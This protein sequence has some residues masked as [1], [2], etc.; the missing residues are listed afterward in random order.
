MK[1]SASNSIPAWQIEREQT[2]HRI[3]QHIKARIARGQ[4]R[5]KAVKIFSRRRNGRPL[6]SDPARKCA[7]SG[8]T[9][10]RHYRTWLRAGETPSAFRLRF[11]PNARR[12][13]APVLVRFVNF[14]ADRDFPSLRAAWE[15][16]CKRGGNYGPGRVRGRRLNLGYHSLRWNLPRGCFR[17]LKRC[18][19]VLRQT[20]QEI[21]VLRERTIA[22]IRA[23]VPDRLPRRIDFQI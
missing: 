9:L 21:A 22:D 12:I 1:P 8:G 7:I 5:F 14:I 3:C 18:R 2:L 17:E 23:R 16:F 6:K 10:S 15:T 20:Q 11:F 4:S 13:P 19:T